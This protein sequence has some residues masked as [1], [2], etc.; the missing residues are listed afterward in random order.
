MGRQKK[1]ESSK[2]HFRTLKNSPS[3]AIIAFANTCLQAFEEILLGNESPGPHLTTWSRCSHPE[4]KGSKTKHWL[5]LGPGENLQISSPPFLLCTLDNY[6]NWINVKSVLEPRVEAIRHLQ[7]WGALLWA[8]LLSL[9][10]P[11]RFVSLC[12]SSYLRIWPPNYSNSP[13]SYWLSTGLPWPDGLKSKG[14]WASLLSWHLQEDAQRVTV[15]LSSKTFHTM[16]TG[17]GT[18]KMASDLRTASECGL[19]NPPLW[20]PGMFLPCGSHWPASLE[21]MSSSFN[22]S[23]HLPMILSKFKLS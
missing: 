11:S 6:K 13:G 4:L 7:D 23:C 19:P 22:E 14:L 17:L 8:S 15:S 3:G 12:V 16:L 10:N 5:S 9:F 20:G 18:Y 21:C 2:M 1:V